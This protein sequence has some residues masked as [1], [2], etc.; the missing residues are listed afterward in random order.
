MKFMA[1]PGLEPKS[2]PPQFMFLLQLC[3]E[4][5]LRQCRGCRQPPTAALYSHP[6]LGGTGAAKV[7]QVWDFAF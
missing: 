3:E 5:T 6:L 4:L 1:R 2:G 7:N